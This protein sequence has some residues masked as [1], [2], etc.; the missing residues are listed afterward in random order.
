MTTLI[1]NARIITPGLQLD[2]AAV[3][4]SEGRIRA[5]FPDGEALPAA[6]EVIDAAGKMLMPGFIDLHF[7]GAMGYETTTD[8]PQ[9]MAAIGAQKLREGV[10]SCCP[11]TLT[12]PEERLATSLG[13]I[14]RYRQS[15]EGVGI[16]G[17]HLEGPYV[18]PECL[19]AQN[20]AFQRNPS[21][22]EIRRLNAISPVKLITYAVELPGAIP[23][24]DDLLA[25]GIIP[26]CGHSNA[27]MTQ[28]RAGYC[29]GLR[30]LTHFCNQMTKLH[31]RSIGLV[32]AGF[33]IPDVYVEVI[34]DKI[35]LCEDMIRLVFKSKPL[36]HILLITDAMEAS[37][38]QP[39]NYQLGGLA[40]VV[41]DGAARLASNGAL[42]GS[43]LKMNEAL[44][45]V[46]EVTG[47]P[48]AE[49]VRTTA[50]NQAEE[51]GIA[52]L[53]RI[54]AGYRADLALLDDSFNVAQVFIGGRKKL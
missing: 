53:G 40:V 32:G 8:S 22:A 26:S 15:G 30:R 23:F 16:P 49:I 41:S 24:T 13:H 46:R 11:T 51:L 39:G 42:A 9:A 5:L 29:H 7:H 14:E 34:C 44:R 28:F 54:Q 19:G 25:E 45:N 47:L 18:N 10:T 50:L 20:P 43:I 48:L 38:L 37:G 12:L 21:I 36:S 33:F 6:D 52:D 27:D 3:L 2:N 1:K 17:V 4:T 31:H 35:H